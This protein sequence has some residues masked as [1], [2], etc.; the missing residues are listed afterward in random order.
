MNYAELLAYLERNWIKTTLRAPVAEYPFERL[1][2]LLGRLGSPELAVE[3]VGVTGSKGKG[4]IARLLAGVLQE[5][6][7]RAGLFTSPHLERVEERVQ[8]DGRPLG[9]E[10]F[11]ERFGRALAEQRAGGF[12]DLGVTPLLMG[13]ALAWFRDEGADVAVLEVRAGGRFDPTNVAPSRTV[14]VGPIGL[15]HVPGLGQNVAEIAW[16]KAGLVKAGAECFSD[17]QAPEA[18]A[19]L[20]RECAGVGTRLYRVGRELGYRVVTRDEWGQTVEL[21]T[22]RRVLDGLPLGL[23]GEHQAANAAVALAAAEAI[24][25]RRGV[26]LDREKV[27]SAL[28]AARWPGR[29]ERLR[30]APLVLYD[31]A[32]TPESAAAL[33]RALEDHFPGRRWSFVLG[34][35]SKKNAAAILEALS[36]V[37]ARVRC[38]PIEGFD[39][40]GPEERVVAARRVGMEA[41][42]RPGVATALGEVEGFSEPV[43]VTGTLYLYR[44]AREAIAGE[45]AEA[46]PGC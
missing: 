32:H 16:Q 34:M 3:C 28:G 2:G 19:M 29:L 4:S 22:P 31:G 21:R 17:R 23:L 13:L 40:R 41:E 5:H 24:L 12:E 44:A 6:G 1:R 30:E 8:L 10:A 43:C 36:P 38:V 42:A 27:A 46:P 26:E 25:E 15:E 35:L 14:C 20:E 39:H 37:A 7:L 45:K 11:A 9:S 33:A 18:E